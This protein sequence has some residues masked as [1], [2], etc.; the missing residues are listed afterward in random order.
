MV[1]AD[2]GRPSRR[3]S[4]STTCLTL[5]ST[6]WDIRTGKAVWRGTSETTA[7]G[8]TAAVTADLANLLIARMKAD[9]VI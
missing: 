4:S 2:A 9:G 3:R 5:E 1:R 8:D 6:L 7:R